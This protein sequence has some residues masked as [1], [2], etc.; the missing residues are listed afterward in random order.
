MSMQSAHLCSLCRRLVRRRS[1]ADGIL[2]YDD[3]EFVSPTRRALLPQRSSMDG[4]R[5]GL[6]HLA[7]EALENGTADVDSELALALGPAYYLSCGRSRRGEESMVS[8][9]SEDGIFLYEPA[10]STPAESVYELPIGAESEQQPL[11]WYEV[12]HPPRSLGY[13]A[14]S[15]PAGM[16]VMDIMAPLSSY[17]HHES[18]PVLKQCCNLDG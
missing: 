5:Q 16:Q 7:R 1:S 2:R 8:T 17:I 15:V 10:N 14:I 11:W 9:S 3:S 18:P 13:R 6:G 12:R 4:S